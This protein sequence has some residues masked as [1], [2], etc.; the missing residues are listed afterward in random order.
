MEKYSGGD[1]SSPVLTYHNLCKSSLLFSL[2]SLADHGR[3]DDQ[4]EEYIVTGTKFTH[5]IIIIIII[6]C[7]RI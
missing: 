2:N 1:R 6:N 4:N 7:D 5:V 3:P